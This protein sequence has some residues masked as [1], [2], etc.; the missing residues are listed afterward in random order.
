MNW[1]Y[2]LV[3]VRNVSLFF[4][5]FLL[6]L[7]PP[8]MHAAEFFDPSFGTENQIISTPDGYVANLY[9]RNGQF[10]VRL[11]SPDNST[12]VQVNWDLLAE[13]K[14][15][16]SIDK[17][18]NYPSQSETGWTTPRTTTI[19][20]TNVQTSAFN[21]YYTLGNSSSKFTQYTNL[22]VNAYEFPA[23]TSVTYGSQ[24]I[25]I[26]KNALSLGLFLGEFPFDDPTNDVL[27][28]GFDLSCS[29]SS[30]NVKIS[31]N[32][33]GSYSVSCDDTGSVTL[34]AYCLID[35]SQANINNVTLYNPN[36]N[37]SRT[38]Y[39]FH[40]PV[41][42]Y[43]M[44][45]EMTVMLT[46]AFTQPTPTPS[47]PPP[48]YNDSV[49]ML[50]ENEINLA[51]TIYGLCHTNTTGNVL[52]YLPNSDIP[53][54]ENLCE[55]A[56][57]TNVKSPNS[58][59][60]QVS[61]V[62]IASSTFSPNVSMVVDWVSSCSCRP[63]GCL[64][65]DI[66]TGVSTYYEHG[67]TI[68]YDQCNHKCSCSYGKLI[69]CCRERRDWVHG[70]SYIERLRYINTLK[71]AM[72]V[73]PYKTQYTALINGHK[74]YFTQAYDIS[75]FLAYHREYLLQF[76]NL[77]R[78]IDCR[79]TIPM[80]T[81]TKEAAI[82]FQTPLYNGYVDSVGGNGD[83]NNNSCVDTGLL[84]GVTGPSGK[85]LSRS[86]NTSVQ[87]AFS[88]AV[89]IELLFLTNPYPNAANFSSFSAT[90]ENGP[91]FY[92]AIL[93]AIGG[94]LCSQDAAE[95]PEFPF[96]HA[97]IDALWAAWQSSS[98]DYKSVVASNIDPK[99]AIP[100]FNA[101]YAR[102][103]SYCDVSN[104]TSDDLLMNDT[105]SINICYLRP[106]EFAWLDTVLIPHGISGLKSIQKMQVYSSVPFAHVLGL[107]A[108]EIQSL[109]NEVYQ[110]N[111]GDGNPI[112]TYEESQVNSTYSATL[113]FHCARSILAPLVN[114]VQ[115][116]YVQQLSLS[117]PPEY[118]STE[119]APTTPAPF[120]IS[121]T[122]PPIPTGVPYTS[123]APTSPIYQ[124]IPPTTTYNTTGTA[125]P[126]YTGTPAPTTQYITTQAPTTQP[127]STTTV[128][129]TTPPYV[130][131][132]Q[133]ATTQ[134]YVTTTQAATTQPYVPTTTYVPTTQYVAPTTTPP[135]TT[136][137]VPTTQYV[138]PTTASPYGGGG[139]P[140]ATPYGG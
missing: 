121:V 71:Y 16:G 45:Y 35:R 138:A 84:S 20:G 42:A 104:A 54:L 94:T 25:T 134:P 93:C 68:A 6:V 120:N 29:S 57:I 8:C 61:K 109:D 78:Q 101:T 130:T 48:T 112:L 119:C 27:T 97:Y 126:V 36:S 86:F 103:A 56:C 28:F 60:P 31:P 15:D 83:I 62:P 75:N 114:Y 55:G 127:Y 110:R 23:S 18:V 136:P 76:E 117:I 77:L 38:A 22:Q 113:G 125:T 13:V 133:A 92:G 139:A 51:G 131:T 11:S 70:M 137:Y 116:E 40:V 41:Y 90:L 80:Y 21:G 7:V 99:T 132:M 95:A 30:G 69:N 64:V 9:K 118:Q 17:Q 58:C 87:Y 24:T 96:I 12:W 34:P 63:K 108:S 3:S 72:T 49:L 32:S 111:G 88:T 74:Q 102:V 82:P 10:G 85:C 115:I 4:F 135:T 105:S 98:A 124:T 106:T 123:P 79:V 47:P 140:S 5:L 107:S 26:P 65:E 44:K 89:D 19:S 50:V 128:A 2:S 43:E 39:Q 122:P 100:G 46:G 37:S 91:G 73:E 81:W 52:G 59:I 66:S 33:D 67:A 53:L 1:D 129:P 14:P